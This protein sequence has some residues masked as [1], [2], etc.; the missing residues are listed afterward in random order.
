M[1]VRRMEPILA[2]A[3]EQEV[4]SNC[5]CPRQDL[6]RDRPEIPSGAFAACALGRDRTSRKR[7]NGWG[8]AAVQRDGGADREL[9]DWRWPMQRQGQNPADR[10]LYLPGVGAGGRLGCR[11]VSAFGPSRGPANADR[12]LE[13]ASPL[14]LATAGDE[15]YG[16]RKLPGGWSEREFPTCWPSN[17]VCGSGRTRACVSPTGWP[18]RLTQLGWTRCSGSKGPGSTFRPWKYGLLGSQLLAVARRSTCPA[19][20][21]WLQPPERPRNWQGG[22]PP[23]SECFEQAK[24]GG[25]GPA[26]SERLVPAHGTY[27]APSR[28]QLIPPSCPQDQRL[29]TPDEALIP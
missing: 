28:R 29:L 16:T 23:S 11:R 14:R 7:S 17:S 27:D 13:S 15:V 3:L 9:S 10:E 25:T 26:R 1:G 5:H 8:A 2:Q 21:L 6:V 18:R 4:W 20:L 22:C 19:R 12:A 24:P